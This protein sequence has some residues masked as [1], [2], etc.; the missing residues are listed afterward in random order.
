MQGQVYFRSIEDCGPGVFE[1]TQNSNGH[2]QK[3][4]PGPEA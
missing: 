2:I 1:Y 3:N 4:I